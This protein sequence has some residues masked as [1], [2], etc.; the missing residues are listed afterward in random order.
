MPEGTES[1]A[2]SPFRLPV[3]ASEEDMGPTEWRGVRQKVGRTI[4][5]VAAAAGDSLAEILGVPCVDTSFDAR[6]FLIG[7]GM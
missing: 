7:S 5:T 3:C 2:L 6:A 1:Y 4:E